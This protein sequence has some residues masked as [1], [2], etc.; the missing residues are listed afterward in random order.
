MAFLCRE[1][2]VHFAL[3][4]PLAG[5]QV[6]SLC[7]LTGLGQVEQ[8]ATLSSRGS[9]SRPN[10]L[11]C[12]SKVEL[13][14]IPQYE[15]DHVPIGLGRE[16][17]LKIEGL[18]P[19]LG[20]HSRSGIPKVDPRFLGTQARL[21]KS[22]Q[23]VKLAKQSSEPK[24]LKSHT[25]ST[26]RPTKLAVSPSAPLTSTRHFRTQ[27][28][29]FFWLLFPPIVRL[30]CYRALRMLGERLYG[31]E[32]V[33]VQRLP[34]GFYLKYGDDLDAL[35]NE[36]HALETVRKYTSILCPRPIDVASSPLLPDQSYLLM[37]AI[38]GGP[39]SK[40]QEAL[41][42]TDLDEVVLQLQDWLTQ[43]RSIPKTVNPTHAICNTLGEALRDPRVRHATPIGPFV[44]EMAFNAM[45]R[46]SDDTSRLGHEIC[47]THA[48][49]NPRNILVDQFTLPNGKSGWRLTGIVD[50]ETA[51]YYPEYWEY[52]KALYEGFRWTNRY[53]SMVKRVFVALGDYEGELMVEAKS[54][55]EGDGI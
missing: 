6:G 44:D 16:Q 45:L 46:Y 14:T 47:F 49:L 36:F 52:T 39:L 22:I 11:V 15:I 20:D 17:P 35:R 24:D 8:A 51:G 18:F 5:E 33:I 4:Y 1:P 12:L 2:R 29:L 37:S 55:G 32:H 26:T 13:L 41:L 27:M 31:V 25:D 3:P 7:L 19:L 28:L 43:L 54:W 42:D 40:Y 53:N 48:D 38:P 23:F 34:F 30:L 10:H 50:W 9:S 21:A